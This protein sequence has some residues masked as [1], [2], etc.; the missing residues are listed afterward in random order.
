VATTGKKKK[1]KKV[2]KKKVGLPPAP[3]Q[4]RAREGEKHDTFDSDDFFP[5]EEKKPPA[6]P[7]KFLATN[8]GQGF[9]NN[10]Q[11][12]SAQPKEESKKPSPL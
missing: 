2:K 3:G 6:A 4:E 1:V 12:L 9:G 7:I 10:Q 5:Q 11:S 8:Y